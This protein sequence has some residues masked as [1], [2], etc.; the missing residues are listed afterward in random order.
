MKKALESYFETVYQEYK[1]YEN[2]F[3]S[4]AP[5][6]KEQ[7]ENIAKFAV[8]NEA[9]KEIIADK[10]FE[11]NS[12]PEFYK[13]DLVNLQRKVVDTF[14]A[15]KE[16]LE[17]PAEIIR[18]IEGFIYPKQLYT[19]KNNAAQEIDVDYIQSLKKEAKKQYEIEIKRFFENGRI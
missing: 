3:K 18:E 14:N 2:F 15:V 9:D 12:V 1:N 6:I 11:I 16:V 5:Q 10:L 8:E 7:R 13:N 4:I 17:I 19:I